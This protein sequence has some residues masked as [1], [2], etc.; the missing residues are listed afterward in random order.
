[1]Q[2]LNVCLF[3]LLF[4]MDFIAVCINNEVVFGPSVV[5]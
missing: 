3:A 2:I 5:I 4:D 1:M